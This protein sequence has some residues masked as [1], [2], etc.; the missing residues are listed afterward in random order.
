M[1]SLVVPNDIYGKSSTQ[2]GFTLL[3]NEEKNLNLRREM[4]IEN[5]YPIKS[6]K[7]LVGREKRNTVLN[8]RKLKV[9]I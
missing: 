4:T 1:F 8:Q 5:L 6:Q 9:K 7:Q 3:Y 2:K